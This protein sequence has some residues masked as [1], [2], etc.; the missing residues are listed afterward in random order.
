MKPNEFVLTILQVAAP[1]VAFSFGIWPM[2]IFLTLWL[3]A[4]GVAEWQSKARTGKTLSQWVWTM[5]GWKRVVISLVMVSG[6]GA[7]AFHFIWG[8]KW[9]G[10]G[11]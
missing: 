6:M 9:E 11:K 8:T 5:P 4:F 1:I 7:L 3:I 10:S 2:G